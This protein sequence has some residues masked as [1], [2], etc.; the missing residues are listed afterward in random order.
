MWQIAAS[1]SIS[2]ADKLRVLVALV[3]SIGTNFTVFSALATVLIAALFGANVAMI[4]YYLRQRRQRVRQAG[5]TAAATSLGGVA[6]GLFGVGCAACGT[7]VLS[8]ALTFLGAGGLI[9]LLPFGGE[10]FG[11]LGVAM[12]GLSLVITARKIAQPVTCAVQASEPTGRRR[13]GGG[14]YSFFRALAVG[15]GAT[16]NS[17]DQVATSRVIE[18]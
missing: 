13:S 14:S 2:L 3:G 11:L 8:P 6:S 4:A 10:E 15:T 7:F 18:R 16:K 5:Q 17:K 9:A 1:G 12:L